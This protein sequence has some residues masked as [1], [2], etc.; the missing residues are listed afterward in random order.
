MV[1]MGQYL[2]HRAIT[3]QVSFDLTP[4]EL[5]IRMAALDEVRRD[6]KQDTYDAN[7]SAINEAEG[8]DSFKKQLL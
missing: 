2:R 4:Q 1:L 6:F 5:W 3:G 7:A 8:N